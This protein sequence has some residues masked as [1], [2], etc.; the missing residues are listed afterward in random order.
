MAKVSDKSCVEPKK[1]G[2]FHKWGVV[3]VLSLALAIILIDATLLNV[4]LSTLVKDLNTDIQSL[5]WVITAYSLT[6]AA[7][8]ITGGR[9]GDLFG[10]KKMFIVGAVLFAIGSLIASIAGNVTTMIIGESLIEGVGAALM[11]PAT[12]SLLVSKY[13]GRDRGIAFG[14]WGGVAAAST[15]IGPLLGGWLTTNYSW[16]YG[17]RINVVVAAILIAGSYIIT[18]C[19]DTEEKPSLD[20]VGVVLSSLGM[21]SMVFGIIE[22]STY[23]WWTAKKAFDFFGTNYNLAYNLSIVPLA[24]AVGGILLALFLIWERRVERIGKTPLVS[25]GL[26]KNRQFVS[27]MITTAIMSLGQAGLIFSIPVFLQAVRGSDAFHT[28]LALLPMSLMALPFALLGGF[29]SHKYSPKLIIQLGLLANTLAY[30][31]LYTTLQV[32]SVAADFIPAFAIMGIGMGLTMA[33]ISNLTL[34]AV[35]PE[36]SGEASGVNNTMRQVGATLGTAIIGAIMLTAISANISTGIKESKVI[37]EPLKVTADEMV[38]K[39]SS[40]VEFGGG[41]K[42]PGFIPKQI[43]DEITV[44]SH[45]A[46]TDANKE[47]LSYAVLFALVGL[48]SSFWLPK[49]THIETE[50]SLVEAK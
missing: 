5:Q 2:F 1:E 11:M 32:S 40:A 21:F 44:I 29:L 45:K 20:G 35:S 47:A 16:R 12:A 15:A 9:L 42:L 14:I 7:L 30:V 38:S 18:E 4:S 50:K 36:Q 49:G 31:L 25:L 43:T 39:Q 26:F 19:R 37:P 13:K 41:A 28:G 24:I 27:G 23:G 33:T 3:L 48:L 46:I 22:S 8:T 34:S 10:R 17:F 6:I